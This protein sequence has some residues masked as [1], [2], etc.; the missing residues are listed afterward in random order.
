MKWNVTWLALKVTDTY[1]I[2]ITLITSIII[3]FLI[4]ESSINFFI[5]PFEMVIAKEWVNRIFSTEWKMVHVWYFCW[6]EYQWTCEK[7]GFVPLWFRFYYNLR[8]FRAFH[9][10]ELSANIFLQLSQMNL[11]WLTMQLQNVGG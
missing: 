3:Q 1:Y 2:N 8:T 10:I 5:T 9:L 11:S 6:I 4:V 7:W